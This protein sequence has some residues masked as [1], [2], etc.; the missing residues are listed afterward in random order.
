MIWLAIMLFIIGQA[1]NMGT[2]YWIIWGLFVGC[3]IIGIVFSDKLSKIEEKVADELVDILDKH[4]EE[5]YE[6]AMKQVK[7]E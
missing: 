1:L 7:E 6:E 5:L 3:R 4:K 2:A